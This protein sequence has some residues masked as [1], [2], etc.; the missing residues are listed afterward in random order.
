MKRS[1]IKRW[2]STILCPLLH[3]ISSCLADE[4]HNSYGRVVNSPILLYNI[5]PLTFKPAPCLSTAMLP[6]TVRAIQ[7][8]ET[9]F[10][11]PGVKS[12]LRASLDSSTAH[13]TADAAER[14]SDSTNPVTM[15][16]IDSD[17][18]RNTLWWV[19]WSCYS[20]LSHVVQSGNTWDIAMCTG[21]ITC[22]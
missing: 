11:S 21:M 19:L 20:C 9:L 1:T 10:F 6:V 7:V 5:V 2:P 18:E 8:R 15:R 3:F 13:N 16:G 17:D 14:F 12:G 4:V 22:A